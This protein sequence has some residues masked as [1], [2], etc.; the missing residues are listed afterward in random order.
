MKQNLKKTHSFLVA[1][2][3]ASMFQM[4]T[5]MADND[6]IPINN[7]QDSID[8]F[9][10][11]S[12]QQTGVIQFNNSEFGNLSSPSCSGSCA[13]VRTRV[14]PNSYGSVGVEVVGG[15]TWQINSHEAGLAQA[16][17]KLIEIR[18]E[19]LA[20]QMNTTLMEKLVNAIENNKPERT[21][22][23]AIIL[24]KRLGYRDYRT[25]IRDIRGGKPTAKKI[26]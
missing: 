25:L 10:N 2:I 23:I 5:A 14:S 7:N 20:T 17:Q 21:N 3:S 11:L 1:F 24:A 15:F 19:N 18:K 12:S 26:D 22:A 9:N 6:L 8:N 4:P 16:N 13:Y